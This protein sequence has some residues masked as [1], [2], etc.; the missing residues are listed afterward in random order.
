MRL[1]KTAIAMAFVIAVIALFFGWVSW[2]SDPATWM[3]ESRFFV[4]FVALMFAGMAG[5][6]VWSESND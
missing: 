2:F 1:V 6:Y 3:P 5:T 4:G